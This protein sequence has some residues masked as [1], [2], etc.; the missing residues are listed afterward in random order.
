LKE[1]IADP[2]SAL[3]SLRFWLAKRI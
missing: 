3:L 2:V 1:D